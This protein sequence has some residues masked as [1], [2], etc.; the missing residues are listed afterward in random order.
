MWW[1]HVSVGAAS[2]APICFGF[3]VELWFPLGDWRWGALG[4]LCCLPLLIFYRKQIAGWL[5]GY[6]VSLWIKATWWLKGNGRDEQRFKALYRDIQ[7]CLDRMNVMSE[8]VHGDPFEIP[9][10]WESERFQIKAVA[11]TL[12]RLEIPHFPLPKP[13]D[14]LLEDFLNWLEY[15]STLAPMAKEGDIEAARAIVFEDDVNA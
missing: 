14:Y 1:K 9:R 11:Y 13:A 8:A 2:L 4:L 15:L 12:N 5:R 10:G 6:V 3:L 7:A